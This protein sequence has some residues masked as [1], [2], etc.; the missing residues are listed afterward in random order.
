MQRPLELHLKSNSVHE[1]ETKGDSYNIK[2]MF[3][4]SPRKL[5]LNVEQS[6]NLA[7]LAVIKHL[8]KKIYVDEE[9]E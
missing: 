2:F 3:D 9:R 4:I 8:K 1:P 5:V 7:K 6:K